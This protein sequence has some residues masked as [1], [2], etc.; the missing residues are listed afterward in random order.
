MT[1][2][3]IFDPAVHSVK[4]IFNDPNSVLKFHIS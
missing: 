4:L 3:F 1:P 2:V